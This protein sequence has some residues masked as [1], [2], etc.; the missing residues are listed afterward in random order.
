MISGFPIRDVL[1]KRYKQDAVALLERI[2][3]KQDKA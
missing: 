3:N 1:D 2:R